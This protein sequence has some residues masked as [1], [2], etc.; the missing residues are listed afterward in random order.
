M[1]PPAG[2]PGHNAGQTYPIEILDPDEVEGLLRARRRGATGLRDRALIAVL[3]RAGLRCSEVTALKPADVDT[4]LGECHVL[5]G[6]GG[7]R[8]VV[9]L[10]EGACT[11]IDAWMVERA[12]LGIDGRAPLFCRIQEPR[13]GSPLAP[14]AVREML[15]RAAAKAGIT[16]RVHPHGLRHTNAA[17]MAG[18][19]VPT[20]VVQR[21]LGHTRLSTTAHYIGHLRPTAVIAAGRARSWSV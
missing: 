19:G 9:G 2:R 7:R 4:R 10:D 11:L 17:E 5:R 1:T 14:Q 15:R 20:H 18:E 6:K 13:R 16:K 12:R 3:Y 21:H 8:R